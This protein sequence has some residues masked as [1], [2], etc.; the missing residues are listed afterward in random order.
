M[1]EMQTFVINDANICLFATWLCCGKMAERINVL[2]EVET[3]GDSRHIVLDGG[4]HPPAVR[5][6]G[7]DAAFARLLAFCF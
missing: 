2:F 3:L 5:C 4:P 1:Q 6:G 7:F